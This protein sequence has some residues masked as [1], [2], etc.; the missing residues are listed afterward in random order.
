MISPKT[1]ESSH[2]L[3]INKCNVESLPYDSIDELT[4]NSDFVKLTTS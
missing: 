4:P 1:K 3:D 2:Q